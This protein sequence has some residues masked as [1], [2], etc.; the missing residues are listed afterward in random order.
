MFALVVV[1]LAGVMLFTQSEFSGTGLATFG[2]EGSLPLLVD[3]ENDSQEYNESIP[4]TPVFV[5]DGPFDPAGA[6]ASPG[7]F[8]PGSFAL[9]ATIN[10]SSCFNASDVASIND[11]IL[12][13]QN[14]TTPG[15]DGTY[16][17]RLD[18]ANVTFD[19]QG[20]TINGS[21]GDTNGVLM[22]TENTTMRNCIVQEYSGDGVAILGNPSNVTVEN[23][24]IRD[25]SDDGISVDAFDVLVENTSI[26]G[27]GD[28]GVIIFGGT[29][30]FT[31][32]GGAIRDSGDFG[33]SLSSSSNITFDGVEVTGSADEGI[34][35]FSAAADVFI[36]DSN[37]TNSTSNPGVSV[38]DSTFVTV[39]NS[40]LVGN[41][42]DGLFLSDSENITV[43]NATIRDNGDDG[44]HAFDSSADVVV[45]H[46]SFVNNSDEAFFGD[47]RSSF[48]T[49]ENNTIE[50]HDIEV[51]FGTTPGPNISLI[52]NTIE[53]GNDTSDMVQVDGNVSDPGD[54]FVFRG[55]TLVTVTDTSGSDEMLSLSDF[56]NVTVANNSH[57][58]LPEDPG[59]VFDRCND[60][61][62][63]NNSLNSSMDVAGNNLT[64]SGNVWLSDF[65]ESLTF[66]VPNI[67]V[68]GTNV[69][70]RDNQNVT[71]PVRSDSGFLGGSSADRTFV[72]N[73]FRDNARLEVIV[74]NAT[75]IVVENNQWRDIE[76]QVSEVGGLTIDETT[77]SSVQVV[78]RNNSFIGGEAGPLLPSLTPKEPFIIIIEANNTALVN[79]TLE[80]ASLNG[81]LVDDVND[82]DVFNNTIS[83]LR[84]TMFRV[85]GESHPTVGN[86]FRENTVTFVL[87]ETNTTFNFEINSTNVTE[88]GVGL[89]MIGDVINTSFFNNTVSVS[90]PNSLTGGIIG[91]QAVNTTNGRPSG[92]NVS[93][94]SFSGMRVGVELFSADNFTV[95]NSSLVDSDHKGVFLFEAEGVRVSGNTIL[96]PG[97]AKSPSFV[98]AGVNVLRS[99]NTVVDNNSVSDYLSGLSVLNSSN[100]TVSNLTASNVTHGV[101]SVESV[102]N[103]FTNVTVPSNSRLGF[104]LLFTNNSVINGSLLT[105]FSRGI[106]LFQSFNNVLEF[107]SQSGAEIG[108]SFDLSS[109]NN[110]A[111]NNSLS[112]NSDVDI[113][114]ALFAANNTGADNTFATTRSENNGSGNSIT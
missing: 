36:F 71:L 100:T 69:T 87:N 93:N 23:S 33:V 49:L 102:G 27:N 29:S 47:S 78:V 40:T 90:N 17:V 3:E 6:N 86:V 98:E 60:C 80:N 113:L 99:T 67:D 79:N 44:V 34:I 25:N 20:F 30:V 101:F 26:T 62:V 88:W 81:I 82:N 61:L 11:T 50:G 46:S 64:V 4:E 9:A 107:N 1:A 58:G 32:R 14:V 21:T 57:V 2:E 42:N 97:I 96:A 92:A 89:E 13:T 24:T 10:V 31:M 72:N 48:I 83:D 38:F 91:V 110:L 22:D 66:T 84:G 106:E 94:S 39:E 52:N 65:D 108:L 68:D 35:V 15:G 37:V 109:S 76:V 28:E 70:F 85:L 12:L 73:T 105:T 55:N 95:E 74:E 53:E 45:E 51:R 104:R 19:C 103:T 41:G 7:V 77:E 16:C 111:N 8:A 43:R 56:T 114:F 63:A 59:I 112:G 54:V 75:G 18:L 5:R